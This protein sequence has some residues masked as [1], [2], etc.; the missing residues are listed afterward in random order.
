MFTSHCNM[1][2][3]G[4]EDIFISTMQRFKGFFITNYWEEVWDIETS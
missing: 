1:I 2:G 4:H 3:K